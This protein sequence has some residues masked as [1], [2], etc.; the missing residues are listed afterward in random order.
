M[1]LRPRLV[2]GTL[3][4]LKGRFVSLETLIEVLRTLLCPLPNETPVPYKVLSPSLCTKAALGA[5]SNR[6]RFYLLLA[7]LSFLRASTELFADKWFGV[8]H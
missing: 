6:L 2:E 8:R 4:A 7:E 5:F 3:I 1:R